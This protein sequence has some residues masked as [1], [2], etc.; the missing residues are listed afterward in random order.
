MLVFQIHG[1]V[2]TVMF[3]VPFNGITKTY[4]FSD[5]EIVCCYVLVELAIIMVFC[6]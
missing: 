5:L 3:C 1:Q 4:E 2:C 6:L